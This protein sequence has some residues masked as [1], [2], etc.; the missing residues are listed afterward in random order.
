[1]HVSGN[2]FS[3]NI[4]KITLQKTATQ[5]NNYSMDIASLL[6]KHYRLLQSAMTEGVI[7]KNQAAYKHDI[8]VSAWLTR[9]IQ[10]SV[11]SIEYFPI[12]A[13]CKIFHIFQC[14]V[15]TIIGKNKDPT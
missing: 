6:L 8:D 2:T 13:L 11:K 15:H 14:T 7:D 1:M 4:K 5:Y 12:E 3:G 9:Y 10:W